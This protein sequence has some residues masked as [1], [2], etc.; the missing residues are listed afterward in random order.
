MEH[1]DS[2]RKPAWAG[3][4]CGLSV[5]LS[6][7]FCSWLVGAMGFSAAALR[8]NARDHWIAWDDE[9]RR[10]HLERVVCLNRFLIRPSVRC[11]HLASHVLGRV[12]RCLPSDFEKRYD[13]RPYLVE[14]Y[15]DEGVNGTCIRAPNFVRVG[16]TAGRGRQDRQRLRTKSV[17]SVFMYALERRWRQRL[18]VPF[19]DHTPVLAPAEG[20]N[21]DEWAKNEF[22]GATLGDKRLSAR[23]VRS[24]SLLAAY[25]GQ[26][27][28]ASSDSSHKDIIGFIV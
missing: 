23:L 15:A 3:D 18:G 1:L 24:A 17:K 19:V 27:I 10:A 4:L 2:A 25:P 8:V 12:L 20:L 5:A 22:G 6:N 13:Y 14:T 21:N 11:P 28:N 16:E 9:Q 26:K 7:S